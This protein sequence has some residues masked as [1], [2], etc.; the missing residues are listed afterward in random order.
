[1]QVEIWSDFV[2]PFCYIGKRRLENAL[3]SFPQK[4]QVEVIFK[5]FELDPNAKNR[6]E[7]AWRSYSQRSI[8]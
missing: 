2:C 5:S 1:M 8:M 3:S 7:K 6:M 4:D